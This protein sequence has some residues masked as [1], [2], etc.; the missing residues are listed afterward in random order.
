M[1]TYTNKSIDKTGCSF[2]PKDKCHRFRTYNKCS[3]RHDY[4]KYQ[5][6]TFFRLEETSKHDE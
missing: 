5:N 3:H 1:D 2:K 4:I 6:K